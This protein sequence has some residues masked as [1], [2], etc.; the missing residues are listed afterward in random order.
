METKERNE[1]E[2]EQDKKD[3]EEGMRV[4]LKLQDLRK[5]LEER[6]SIASYCLIARLFDGS[7]LKLES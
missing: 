6:E 2:W 7:T 1:N 4:L 3:S 5:D